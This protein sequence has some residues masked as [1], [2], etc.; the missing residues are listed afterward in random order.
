MQVSP[1]LGPGLPSR[2]SIMVAAARAFGAREPDLSV[3]NPDWLAE[4]FLGP[5]ERELIREHPIAAA[6]EEDYQQARENSVVAGLS[7]FMLIRTRFIDE[8]LERAIQQ[9]A[10][11]VVILG[12]GFDTRAYR[13][14]ELLQGK[15]V[16]EVDFHSTQ[17][18]KKRR[19]TEV[20]GPVPA[21]VRFVEIDFKQDSLR[22][23]LVGAG[24]Q[25]S[26][27]TFFIWEGVSMYLTEEAVRETLHAVATDSAPGSSLVMDFACEALIDAMAMFPNHPQHRYTT[28]WGEPWLF[29]VP[30]TKD[31]E[32]FR[33]TG[34][35]LREAI[36]MVRGD[37]LRRYLTRAD[38]TRLGRGRWGRRRNE[39]TQLSRAVRAL[40]GAASA[41]NV[42]RMIWMALTRR[43]K[44]YALAE[45][46]VPAR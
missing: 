25:P 39:S 41:G 40:R 27:K 44:W 11:Q 20:M 24:Y 37:A 35:A 46:S 2:T 5:A 17:D 8:H 26:Q 1:G 3:R 10:T 34:L 14:Q 42:V 36:S 23:V 28:H 38:G 33:E 16:F 18:F 7:N 19:L 4:R 43:S 13:F 12:A 29:G 21:H 30:D 15:K 32:F 45:L 22:D 6:L 9:G 31:R